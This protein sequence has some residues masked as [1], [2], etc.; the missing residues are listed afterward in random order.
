MTLLV[1]LAELLVSLTD[2]LLSDMLVSLVQV[3]LDVF[4]KVEV[5]FLAMSQNLPGTLHQQC[6]VMPP[7]FEC[8]GDLAQAIFSQRSSYTL[9]F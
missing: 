9:C 6:T 1:Q 4:V 3:Y 7:S 2:E 5:I 8:T